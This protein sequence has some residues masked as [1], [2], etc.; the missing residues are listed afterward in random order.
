MTFSYLFQF[1]KNVIVYICFKFNIYSGSIG[2]QRDIIKSGVFDSQS[3]V[4]LLF[5]SKY[6]SVKFGR[7]Q[8]LQINYRL[9]LKGCCTCLQSSRYT[10]YD[11]KTYSLHSG[12]HVGYFGQASHT[13]HMINLSKPSTQILTKALSSIVR[14]QVIQVFSII[15]ITSYR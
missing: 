1:R 3:L 14:L 12:Y 8:F 5:V 7:I 13:S 11:A 10:L 15:V 9:I 6:E 2:C 4:V